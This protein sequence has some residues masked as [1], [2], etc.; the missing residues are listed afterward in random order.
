MLINLIFAT[1]ETITRPYGKVA[2]FSLLVTIL[3]NVYQMW[4]TSRK[5]KEK[6]AT[7]EFVKQESKV[8]NLKVDNMEKEIA[9]MKK[10]QAEDI[11]VLR[12]DI[13]YIRGRIDAV[14]D[15][16]NYNRRAK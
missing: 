4:N 6:Y 9:E 13:G 11:K 8:V 3:G 7:K 15:G 1:T 16:K 5:N 12:D 14:L 10:D 2:F